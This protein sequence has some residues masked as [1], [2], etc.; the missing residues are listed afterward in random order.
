MTTLFKTFSIQ[1]LE[2]RELMGEDNLIS[3]FSLAFGTPKSDIGG[4]NIFPSFSC[5]F[6]GYE[7]DGGIVLLNELNNSNIIRIK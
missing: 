7:T 6:G 3:S 5:G 2:V 4:G 1:T